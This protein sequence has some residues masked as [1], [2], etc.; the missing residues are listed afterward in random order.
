[1]KTDLLDTSVSRDATVRDHGPGWD[2]HRAF[3]RHRGLI[4]REEQEKLRTRRVAI[5][6]CGGVGGSHLVTLARLGVGRFSIAELDRFELANMNRQFGARM[7]TIGRAKIEVMAEEV[8]RINP[9]VEL[10]LFAEGVSERNIP[11]FLAGA[12][13]FVDGIDFFEIGLRRKLFHVARLARVPAITAGPM[14][15]STAWITFSPEGMSFDRYFDL[16]DDQPLLEQL[17][18]FAV[19]LTPALLQRPYID[20]SEVSLAER[21]GPS[22]AL[23]CELCAGVVAAEAVRI[24]LGRGGVRAAPWYRQFDAYRGRLKVGRL[25]GG[26]RNLFQRLKRWWLL[27]HVRASAGGPLSPTSREKT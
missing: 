8:R 19:G 4:S 6:G 27:R 1:M 20:V 22:A 5:V 17:A 24:L 21:R 13:L 25:W 12:D 16:R 15:F 11:E 10:R 26:N 7:D 18:A 2:Y 23:A 9:D 3:E 14:G